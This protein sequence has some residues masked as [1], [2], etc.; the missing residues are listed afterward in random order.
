VN[1]SA[2]PDDFNMASLFSR[3]IPKTRIPGKRDRNHAP[4]Y[5]LNDQ[6]I[7]IDVNLLRSR[8]LDFNCQRA[9]AE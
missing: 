7:F 3:S 1:Q 4:V 8:L 9:T 2:I 6:G 5:Q